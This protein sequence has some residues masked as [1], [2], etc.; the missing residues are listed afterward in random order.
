[1]ELLEN[2]VN[3]I[4]MQ[5]QEVCLFPRPNDRTLVSKLNST[6]AKSVFRVPS[7]S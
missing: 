5:L 1:M 2:P 3:G 7:R 6:H 4:T